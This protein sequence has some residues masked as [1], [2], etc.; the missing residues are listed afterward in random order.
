[1]K[2]RT[3]IAMALAV[4]LS[5][6]GLAVAAPGRRVLQPKPTKTTQITAQ[7]IK[8]VRTSRDFRGRQTR[9]FIQSK[10]V[11]APMQFSG[12]Q[13][14]EAAKASVAKALVDVQKE[15][16][17]QKRLMAGNKNRIARLRANISKY[18]AVKNG[19]GVERDAIQAELTVLEGLSNPSS[20][21]QSCI[22]ELRGDLNAVKK[23]INNTVKA[24]KEYQGRLR[25]AQTVGKEAKGNLKR[26]DTAVRRLKE[27]SRAL[28]MIKKPAPKPGWKLPINFR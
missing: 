7:T 23:Q 2:Q 16:K 15:V 19:Y 26:L 13:N 18:T 25:F 3:T 4:G 27:A 9:K 28:N 1:M 17:D 22:A 20:A 10:I 8:P 21:I 11:I 12:K 14:V 24:I 5:M 6:T